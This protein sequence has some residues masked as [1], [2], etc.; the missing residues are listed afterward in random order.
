[1]ILI[2]EERLTLVDTGFSGSSTQII[3]FIHRLGRS[4]EELNLIII[5]HNH[6]DHAGGLAELRKLTKAKVAAHE[7]DFADTVIESA[8]AGGIRRL[9]R[10]PPLVE[11]GGEGIRMVDGEVLEP[12]GGLKVLYTPG[13]TADSISLFSPQ[14]KLLMVGDALRKHRG[15]L[16][17]PPKMVSSDLQQAL[18]SV[19]RIAQLDFDILCFGHGRPLTEGARDKV[20]ELVERMEGALFS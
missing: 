18:A 6:L 9:L 5:T 15:T 3:N 12:L 19:K 13:H 4:V 1:M 11:H 16:Y 8:H 10:V 20:L 7:A 14:N 17:L 2:V